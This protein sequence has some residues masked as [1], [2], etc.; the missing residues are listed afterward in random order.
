MG[1]IV[2]S[3]EI[4][5][6]IPVYVKILEIQNASGPFSLDVDL[7]KKKIGIGENL[8]MKLL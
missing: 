1:K 2:F 6:E 5:E 7:E 3:G 4:K 8:N